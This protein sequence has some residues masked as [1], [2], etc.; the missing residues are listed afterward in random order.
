MTNLLSH[1]TFL[2]GNDQAPQLL[3]RV[4]KLIAEYRARIPARSGELTEH[5]SILITYGDQVQSQNEKPLQ[6]LHKFCEKYL[7]D[8]V[9]GIHILPFYPW[10]SDDG[11]S[12]VDYR[13]IDPALG[14]WEDVSAMQGFRLMFDAV[15][16]H[17][18]AQS[19]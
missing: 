11:F 7:M 5:D 2:Y 15:I 14:D 6:T 4:E 10:T 13:Q 18:S 12:V 1:L 19:P 16:N 9:G 3:V 8:L 17:I